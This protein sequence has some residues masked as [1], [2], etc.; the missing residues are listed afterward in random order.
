MSDQDVGHRWLSRGEL[1]ANPGLPEDIDALLADEELAREHILRHCWPDGEVACPRCLER[2]C[3][4]LVDG[5]YRCSGCK[6]TFQD[7]SGRWINNG[8]LNCRQWLALLR[9]FVEEHTT[10]GLAEQLELSYNTAY[11]AL[12]ALRFAL[13]AGGTDA[14]QMFGP[15]TGL[16][17][18]VKG[19]KLT[20][21]PGS[22]PGLIP[23]FGVLEKTRWVFIDLLP[24]LDAETV[25]HFNLNFHLKLVLSGHIGYTDR[26]KGYDTLL[27]CGD[28]SL[29]YGCVRKTAGR[30]YVD[31]SDSTF[32]TF[33]LPRLRRFKGLSTR[34]FPLYIKELEFRF[35]HRDEPLF[36]KVLELLC[37]PV[38]DLK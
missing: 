13:V 30:A 14:M 8:G 34:R 37:S 18:Y 36:E 17:Q 11:K 7:F 32:W 28:D 12:T 26:Y 24:N 31:A 29:P 20:G 25:F 23:V 2:K 6:Y 22:R 5:R 9:M 35:N 10:H 15:G 1:T 21:L 33:A 3:Y 4:G 19:K 16:G 38:P 27:F